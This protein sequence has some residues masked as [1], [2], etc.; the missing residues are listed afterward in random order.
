MI[1]MIDSIGGPNRVNNFLSTLNIK[2]IDKRSL[3]CME[4]RAGNKIE[5]VA[6]RSMETAATETFKMEMM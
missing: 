4:R 5:E 2:P 3:K 6:K 1:A